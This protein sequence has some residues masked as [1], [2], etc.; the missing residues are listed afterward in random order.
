MRDLAWRP[1]LEEL[2]PRRLPSVNVLTYHND[3]ARTGQNLAEPFLTPATV[4][5]STFGKLFS[6]PVDGQ[7]YAQPL[8]MS[9]LSIPGKGVHNVVFVATEHDS[10]YAFDADTNLGANGAPLWHDSFIDPANGVTTVLASDIGCNQIAPEIGITATPVIDPATGTIYVQAMTKE[11]TGSTTSY[12]Q[13]L[14]ALDVSTGAERFGGPVVIQATVAGTGDGGTVDIFNP[15]DYK[16]RPGLLLLGGV[17]YTAWSSHCDIGSYHGWII[18]YNAQTLQQAVVYNVTPNGQQAS[19]WMS[20]AGLA[21]DSGGFIYPMTGNGD[22]DPAHANFGDSFLK[23]APSGS[24]LAVS[25]YFAP[26]DQATLAQKDLDLGSGGALVLPD[27]LGGA[28]HPN[29]LVGAGKQGIIY[30]LDRAA[31]GGF[32]PNADH[33][34]QEFQGIG[35]QFGMPAY[36]NGRVYFGGVGDHLKAFALANGLLGTTPDSQ[37]GNPFGYP[38]TTPS[39][40]ANGTTGGIVWAIENG[41]PAV[42]HAYDATNV[43]TELYNSNQAGTRDQLDQ[44]VKFT[45]PTI[46]NG[47][48]YVGTATTLTVFGL[49]HNVLA[50]TGADAGGGPEVRVFAEPGRALKFDFFAYTPTFSGGVRV[51]VGDVNSDGVPDLVTAPGA[52]M[53][54][55][56]RVWDGRTGALL[57]DFLAYDQRFQNGVYVAA[58]DVNHDGFAD[59]ITGAD[60]GG[61]PHVE[62]FSGKDGTLL[63]SFFAYNPAFP[64]GVRVAAGDVNGDGFADIITGAGPGGGPHVEVWSGKD[65]G[66]LRSFMAYDPAFAGGVYVAAGDTN[67]DHVADVITGAGAGGGPHVEVWSGLDNSILASF[68]AFN[69]AYTGGV[70]V[71][72]ADVNDDGRID[73]LTATGPNGSALVNFYDAPPKALVDTFF[74]YDPRFQGGVFVGGA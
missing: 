74:A 61:G 68:M 33:V 32:D 57:R 73:I 62:V 25:S 5:S 36:F 19:I 64:G 47:K 43:A 65:G 34:V 70:R 67:G 59:I 54:P 18:G 30:L 26:F 48:V 72:A 52:G 37:S 60:R 16:G 12:V 20:G 58:G 66:V 38:G 1:R 31:L 23:L 28:T 11:V 69:P 35:A 39:I 41:N 8:Y 9:A 53:A 45:V 3:A 4:N 46:A 6:V 22:F 44:G 13:R 17:V 14:H 63:Y 29:L 27:G 50:A 71:G 49:F 42:L 15:H 24:T 2:E 10:V 55:D 51:T 56:V 40:S 7:V 21:A